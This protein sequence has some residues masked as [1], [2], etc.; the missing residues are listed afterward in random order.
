MPEREVFSAQ[1]AER[2]INYL[3]TP[4]RR[5]LW[6]PS[7][8]LEFE[9]LIPPSVYP[10]RHDSDLLARRISAIGPGRGKRMLDIGCGAGQIT[11]LASSLGWRVSA[12][13]IN[14]YAVAATRGNLATAALKGEVMEGGV[15]PEKFPFQEKFDLIVWNLPYIQPDEIGDEVL[16]PM[17][18]AAL[19]DTDQKGLLNRLLVCINEQNLLA[20][21]GRVIT[22]SRLEGR[23]FGFAHRE[24]DKLIFDDG[25]E[26][27]LTCL[28]RPWEGADKLLESSTSST[29]ESLLSH[30]GIGTF[31]RAEKQT[32]GRGRRHRDWANIEGCFAGSWIVEEGQ[33][34]NPGHLQLSGGLAV[35][36][37][38]ADSRLK[39]KWPNDIY[40]NGKK[41]CGILAE[42]RNIEHKTRVVLGIGI[43]VK[44]GQHDCEEPI[45]FLDE[46][47]DSSAE[48]LAPILH[49]EL[50]SLLE[51]RPDIPKP[52]TERVR[53]LI[54]IEMKRYGK[55]IFEGETHAD[56]SLNDRGELVL[57]NGKIIDDSEDIEWEIY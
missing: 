24:W 14:P 27:I 42:G 46:I 5:V 49:C 26:L 47:I 53:E 44:R 41:V 1:D 10:P 13:D 6:T 8:R 51:K 43:N 48:E 34:I 15:G 12:C 22:L 7:S 50:A 55:P 20:P 36:N 2:E 23:G 28:W 33:D 40:L 21:G 25:E 52:N 39:L 32:S 9:L 18:E 54:L 3:N 38:V 4:A 17:E 37:S 31:L 11:I 29:N 45:G 56:F 30:R 35:L 16:G 57:S 19:I